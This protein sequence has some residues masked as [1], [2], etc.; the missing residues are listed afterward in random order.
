MKI[1]SIEGSRVTA[2]VDAG[3][4]GGFILD[5]TKKLL[6]EKTPEGLFEEF[7]GKHAVLNLEAIPEMKAVFDSV[8]VSSLSFTE[9]GVCLDAS[10][11]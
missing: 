5:K 3:N 11:K 9:D 6:L 7:D 2:E 10:L 4:R 8:A 1:V